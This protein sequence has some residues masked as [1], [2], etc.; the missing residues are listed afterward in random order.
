M[1]ALERWQC[2]SKNSHCDLDLGSRTLKLK[3]VQHIV[4]VNICV[5]IKIS[6]QIKALEWW[7]SFSKNSH[8][9]LDLDSIMLKREFVRGFV[10]P[11]T[12]MKLYWNRIINEVARAMTKGEHTYV[13]TYVWD[14]PFIPSRTSL[15]EGIISRLALLYNKTS[16][17][18]TLIT[19]LPWL[20]RT[21]AWEPRKKFH[22]CRFG[23][24]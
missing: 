8:C 2:F 10:T 3:L 18:R 24:I 14:R 7:Q 1:R 13:R 22:S 4:I 6:Q 15:C 17:A 19:R 11:N 21:R 5:K 23:I 20:F 16:V 12:C 9:D